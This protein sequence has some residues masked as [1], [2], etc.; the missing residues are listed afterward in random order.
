MGEV[1]PYQS[2]LPFLPEIDVPQDHVSYPAARCPTCN[3]QVTF[4]EALK[5]GT[6]FRFKCSRCQTKFRV[7]AP[8]MPLIFV[9]VC[10]VSLLLALAVFGGLLNP[11][12]S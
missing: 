12:Y 3:V 11:D 6:P 5:Q 8:R 9:S 7:V 2:P 10:F 4:G 1:N